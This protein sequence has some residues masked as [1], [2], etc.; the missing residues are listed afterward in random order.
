MAPP[1]CGLSPLWE[2]IRGTGRA[3]ESAKPFIRLT[4][5]SQLT[6]RHRGDSSGRPSATVGMR[7]DVSRATVNSGLVACVWS[8]VED[9]VLDRSH[10][11]T[12]KSDCFS[13]YL[14]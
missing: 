1:T 5:G 12:C 11:M 10:T 9:K 13:F 14:H 6:Q 7:V 3:S 8:R 2:S 4:G